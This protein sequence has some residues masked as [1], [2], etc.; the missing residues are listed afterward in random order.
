MRT[1][2]AASAGSRLTIFRKKIICQD[3]S[4]LWQQIKIASPRGFVVHGVGDCTQ[5]ND[6]KKEAENREARDGENLNIAQAGEK[7]KY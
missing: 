1:T 6:A 4:P 5:R 3:N 7:G 2:Q